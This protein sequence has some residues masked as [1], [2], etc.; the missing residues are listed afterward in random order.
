MPIGRNRCKI[1]TLPVMRGN[2][3]AELT[4]SVKQQL[5]EVCGKIGMDFI[6]PEDHKYTKGIIRTD[7][8]INAYFQS[9]AP[10]L[11]DIQALIVFSGDFM[12]ER[13]IQDTVRQLPQ[14]VPVFLIVNND[15]PNDMKNIG[16]ALCGTLSA[17][18]NLRMLGRRILKCERINMHDPDILAH[19]LRE[20]DKISRGIESLRNTRVAMLGI[21][22]NE[23]ATTFTNQIKLFELGFSLHTCE[24]L[25]MWGDVV[26]GASID[27]GNEVSSELTGTIKLNTPI[28][29]N[30]PRVKT[31]IKNLEALMPNLPAPD[32]VE[33]IARCFLWVKDRFAK[34]RIDTAAI[35]CWGEFHR[36]FGIAPCTFAM[37]ANAL[38]RIPLVCE[39]DICHALMAKLGWEITGQAPVI[40]DINNNAW[41]PRVFNVFHCSQT[42]ANWLIQDATVCDYGSIEGAIAPQA[43]TG[44]STATASDSMT[45]TV[46]QGHFLSDPVTPKRG[47]S[48]WA[49]VPNFPEVLD[50]IEKQG[51]HHFVAI[52]GYVG[53][54]VADI[55]EFK[56]IQTTNLA[57]PL[58]P[59]TEIEAALPPI[60]KEQIT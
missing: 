29:R 23:F 35:H 17:H 58:P 44:I 37:M 52:K 5:R 43:F 27:E 21:N 42:P 32:K 9:W 25:E 11:S 15:D 53:D 13:V 4:I 18:H 41:D 54:M 33:R 8:D 24:L 10:M 30:D 38:L 39:V 12:R 26:L 47:S 55:L 6:I 60:K 59:L 20:I 36:F 34:D 31:S 2:Y 50:K 48:G 46:F 40:L 7:D 45:A 1:L 3:P 19:S 22:P 16:D 56:G 51:I 49:F 57:S 14:D 28:Y